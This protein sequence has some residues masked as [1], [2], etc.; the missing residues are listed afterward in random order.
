M[1]TIAMVI[2]DCTSE[3]FFEPLDIFK[4]SFFAKIANSFK[5]LTISAKEIFARVLITLL[6][7][8]GTILL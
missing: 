1:L 7:T 5:L 2:F 6:H 3:E 8:L 4:M